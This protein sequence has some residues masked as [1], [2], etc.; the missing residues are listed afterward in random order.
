LNSIFKSFQ[1]KGESCCEVEFELY[2]RVIRKHLG[3]NVHIK[4]VR[5]GDSPLV[6]RIKSLTTHPFDQIKL[7]CNELKND[8]N[9]RNG[10][11]GIG[12]SQGGLLM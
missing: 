3:D 7:V 8:T 6:D 10:Y 2:S 11:N 12:L 9:F 1:F 4:S 5:I